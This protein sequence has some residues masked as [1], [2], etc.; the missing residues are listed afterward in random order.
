[1]DFLCIYIIQFSNDQGIHYKT[2]RT[3]GDIEYVHAWV[4]KNVAD[5]SPIELES[6]LGD[7]MYEAL[8]RESEIVHRLQEVVVEQSSELVAIMD[9]AAEL[10]WWVSVVSIIMLLRL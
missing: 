9:V 5:P 10:D 4:L 6:Q 8:D 2:D 3:K 7:T 1:M